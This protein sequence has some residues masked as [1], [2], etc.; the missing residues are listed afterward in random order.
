MKKLIFIISLI[1]LSF[2]I[3][4][5]QQV[6]QFSQNMFNKLANNPGSAG[7]SQ[8]ITTSVLH[9]SQWMGFDGAPLTQSISIDAPIRMLNGGVGLSIINDE[10][11]PSLQRHLIRWRE[12]EDEYSCPGVNCYNY[13]LKKLK[14]F[15]EYRPES[16]IEH[17]RQY[18]KPIFMAI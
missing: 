5:A 7:S 18:F 16:V 2:G 14:R 13:E 6:P 15:L 8:A 12:D 11:E 3:S 17:L 9:R 4:K 10:I 1:I